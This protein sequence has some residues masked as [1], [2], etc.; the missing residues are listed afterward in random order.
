MKKNVMKSAIKVVLV[1][2]FNFVMLLS[3]GVTA[4]ANSINNINISN[5]QKNN[6]I[7][8]LRT[9]GVSEDKILFLMKKLEKGEIWNSISGENKIE[10]AIYEKNGMK[11]IVEHY[12][13]GS[14][15][16]ITIPSET[17][18][19]I[20]ASEQNQ[21][22]KTRPYGG[23]VIHS[24]HYSKVITDM[25]IE[26]NAIIL[27]IGCYL[28]VEYYQGGANIR[29]AYRSYGHNLFG[30]FSAEE[31]TVENSKLAYFKFAESA[32]VSFKGVGISPSAI[33]RFYIHSNQ[34]GVY[35]TTD[36]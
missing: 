6:I 27:R 2:C 14:I 5:I 36:D 18:D 24:D 25:K 32:N 16:V 3:I 4:N 10:E 34:F 1:L 35:C 17:F 11:H 8:Q 19:T 15:R 30:G 28:E 26:Q 23:R 13:D 33:K 9:Y 29:R 20:S 12:K 31:P 21:S 7:N 22:F